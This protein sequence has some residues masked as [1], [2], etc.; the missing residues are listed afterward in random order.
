MLRKHV[1]S[2]GKKPEADGRKADAPEDETKPKPAK[3]KGKGRFRQ[4]MAKG[5]SKGSGVNNTKT[6]KKVNEG[7]K[8]ACTMSFQKE[9]HKYQY[10]RMA[11]S[12]VWGL[13]SYRV[14]IAMAVASQLGK[15]RTSW[16]ALA[17]LDYISIWSGLLPTVI[18]DGRTDRS[19]LGLR[20]L[21]TDKLQAEYRPHLDRAPITN[22]F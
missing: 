2:K 6:S 18:K 3:G 4:R 21:I 19:G 5:R 13:I 11:T 10:I 20:E 8:K 1:Q 15:L 7:M 9:D 16:A 22:V 14:Q 12:E 17:V